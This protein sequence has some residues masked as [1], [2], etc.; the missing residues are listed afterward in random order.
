MALTTVGDNHH[1]SRRFFT[2]TLLPPAPPLLPATGHIFSFKEHYLLCY[3]FRLKDAL[4]SVHV[5]RLSQGTR[6]VLA[7]VRA[8]PLAPVRGFVQ[9][10]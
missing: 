10:L 5:A 9:V 6:K 3:E 7:P 8:K 4:A 2:N 1:L